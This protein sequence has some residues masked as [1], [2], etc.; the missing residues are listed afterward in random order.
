VARAPG[1]RPLDARAFVGGMPETLGEP[2]IVD[3]IIVYESKL[4]QTGAEYLPRAAI[5]LD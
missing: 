5:P 4:R 3:E 1:R 2:W